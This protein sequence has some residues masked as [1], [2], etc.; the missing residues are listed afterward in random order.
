[1]RTNIISFV[2]ESE[3]RKKIARALLDYP[4][5]QWGCSALED[6]TKISHA[7]VFRTLKG[8]REFGI[9]KSTRINKKD[10]MYELVSESPFVKELV[11]VL[12]ID[13]NVSRDIAAIFVSKIK[14]KEI[15]SVILY[16]SSVQGNMKPDSDIDVLV[17]LA[18]HNWLKE[19]KIQDISGEVSSRVNKTINAVVM[20]LKQLRKE[21]KSRF[22]ESIIE[23]MEV[24]YG[25]KPF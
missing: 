5:R 19:Q 20:D 25:K 23:N 21:K 22:V 6:L 8:L 14:S 2:M 1:M 12:D 10:L 13:K 7:T 24:L 18:K 16:G 11:R 9:L 15:Y 4:E 3:N 17:V